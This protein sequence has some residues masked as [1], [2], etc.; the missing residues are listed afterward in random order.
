MQ[1]GIL[2]TMVSQKMEF[3]QRIRELNFNFQTQAT[4]R[5]LANSNS[6]NLLTRILRNILHSGVSKFKK[7]TAKLEMFA[8]FR[9][10]RL[11]TFLDIP[12]IA[13]F[14]RSEEKKNITKAVPISPES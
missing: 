12:M 14:M 8:Q 11:Q 4:E 13:S 7:L 5:R 9:K 1:M 10:K 2:R 6:G 3:M